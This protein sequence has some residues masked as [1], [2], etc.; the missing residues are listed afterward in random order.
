MADTWW[1]R[2]HILKV[3]L[4]SLLRDSALRVLSLGK[5]I[6]SSRGW[7]RM[8][9]YHGI[10]DAE[11][12]PFAR[13]IDYLRNFGQFVSM[14]DA[15]DLIRG[16]VPMDGRYFSLSFD[17]GFESCSS[18]A[19]PILAERSVPATFYVVSDLVGKRFDPQ[20]SVAKDVFG[21]SGSVELAFMSWENCRTLVAHGM[22]IG[23]HTASH[24]R[25]ATCSDETVV[26]QLTRSKSAIEHETARA[27]LHF[28]V[29]YGV[30]G[31]DFEPVHHARL[32]ADV[33][34]DSFATGSRGPNRPAQDTFAL[35]RDHLE[36]S[37]GLH[38]L[39]YFMSV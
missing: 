34:Y 23:S 25:L 4:R 1:R 32:A 10:S 6:D 28:C 33:G 2:G 8:P 17:D 39:R 37:W 12:A 30:P 14:D 15:L 9:Y 22:A 36:A 5:R 31:R 18:N 3:V 26:D 20:D 24:A 21:Y 19:L 11:Q 13:H 29:P 27:C 7:V 35:K 38:Q 16:R